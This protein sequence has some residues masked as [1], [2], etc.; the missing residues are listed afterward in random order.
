MVKKNHA[1]RFFTVKIR[2]TFS[3]SISISELTISEPRMLARERNIGAY[4]N[5]T[6]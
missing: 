2:T 3:C 5:V 4:Q 6:Y 1:P